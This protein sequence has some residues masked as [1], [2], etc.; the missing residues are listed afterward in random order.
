M[1]Q[2]HEKQN[3]T[4]NKTL[5]VKKPLVQQVFHRGLFNTASRARSNSTGDIHRV[6]ADQSKENERQ[7]SNM[8]QL[9]SQLEQQIRCSVG[10]SK[11]AEH[12]E[13]SGSAQQDAE[14]I[15]WQ[16][17]PEAK[18]KRNRSPEQAQTT[19]KFQK[20]SENRQQLFNRNRKNLEFQ[21]SIETN[22]SFEIFN[23]IDD[24]TDENVS[25]PTT[26]TIAKPK[27]ISK[28]PRI[29]L[30]GI[31]DL[32][33]LTN[34][35]NEVIDKEEYTYNTFSRDELSISS[36]S[37]ESYK[38]LITHIRNKGLIGHTFTRKEERCQKIVL[39]NLHYTTPKEA[40]KE[41]I[42]KSGN[43]V[44][45]EIINARRKGTK[46]PYNVFFVNLEP[47]ENNKLVKN[48]EYIYHQRIKVEDPRKSNVIVQ[49]KRCQKYGH[50]KNYCMRPYKCV[51]CAGPHNTTDCTQDKNTPAM[52]AL[53]GGRHP[54]NYKGCQ[55]YREL[56]NRKKQPKFKDDPIPQSNTNS[57]KKPNDPQS[58]I[59]PQQ[60]HM[61]ASSLEHHGP[62]YSQ[63][64]KIYKRMYETD[65]TDEKNKS[66]PNNSNKQ[67]PTGN[68]TSE[69]ENQYQ[70]QY[71]LLQTINRQTEKLDLLMQQMGT[72]VNLITTLISKK[73]HD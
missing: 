9:V 35:I 69:I 22:N 14:Q 38:K 67:I 3:K 57:N 48:I 15:P 62:T 28:P 44:R 49:C 71:I 13:P 30:Y 50:T 70:M 56:Q 27:K 54:A 1:S 17:V 18:S 47:H 40:I 52:C 45:G 64:L 63:K 37:V 24:E 53:C 32:K 2:N 59:M 16:K 8:S 26:T 41:A 58:I 60:E 12:S 55:V 61:T 39:K 5:H 51:K 19:Y 11:E 31:K 23:I 7:L 68:N 72:L 29:I 25:N 43:K 36:K 66:Q 4:I 73:L 65:K 21:Q 34:L 46:E 42:E 20:R 6:I 33:Q 10:Q